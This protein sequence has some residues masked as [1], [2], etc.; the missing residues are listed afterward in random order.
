[1]AGCGPGR[2]R[3]D[4]RSGTLGRVFGT[5]FAYEN[6]ICDYGTPPTPKQPAG[7]DHDAMMPRVRAHDRMAIVTTMGVCVMLC[8]QSRTEWCVR[9]DERQLRA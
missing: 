6:W 7:I 1:M 5:E 9:C 2:A 4:A 8:T 3:S